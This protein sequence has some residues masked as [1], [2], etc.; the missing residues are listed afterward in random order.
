MRVG[1]KNGHVYPWA[2]T[3]SRPRQPKDQRYENAYPGFLTAA[4][5]FWRDEQGR[6]FEFGLTMWRRF[7]A[8][9]RHSEL[10][11]LWRAAGVGLC[12]ALPCLVRQ[13]RAAA[14]SL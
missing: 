9:M 13:V 10:V 3:G 6:G 1:Q 4:N 11:G 5:L 8:A 14:A 12:D 7:W 2:R